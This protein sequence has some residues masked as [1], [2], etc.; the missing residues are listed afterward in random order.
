MVCLS[1]IIIYL[2]YMP[3]DYYTKEIR[4][5]AYVQYPSSIKKYIE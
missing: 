5:F 2:V 1:D 4:G 3:K